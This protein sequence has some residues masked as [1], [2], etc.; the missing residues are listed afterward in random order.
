MIFKGG[1]LT[2]R[3]FWRI[4]NEINSSLTLFPNLYP[5]PVP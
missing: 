2:T 1:G 4:M 3:D 5:G